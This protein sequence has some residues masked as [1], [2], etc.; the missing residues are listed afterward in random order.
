LKA[1]EPKR[2]AE[3]ESPAAHVVPEQQPPLQSCASEHLS[4]QVWVLV[5]QALPTAQ[6]DALSH[7]QCFVANE[8]ALPLGFSVQSTHASPS[9]PQAVAFWPPHEPFSQQPLL[10]GW[11]GEQALVHVC[12]V[13]SHA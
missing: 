9:P 13:M 8:H 7:P 1:Y 4:V 5:S 6:S 3:A 2:H 12:V 10:H 11:V